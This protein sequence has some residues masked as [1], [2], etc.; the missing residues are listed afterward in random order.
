MNDDPKSRNY[1][2]V[3]ELAEAAGLTTA[4]IRQLLLEGRL[5]GDK[6]GQNWTIPYYVGRMWLQERKSERE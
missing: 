2:S 6:V 1:F 4:R 3:K 5:R